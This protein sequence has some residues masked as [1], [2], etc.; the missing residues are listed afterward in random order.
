MSDHIQLVTA[1]RPCFLA[2]K[3]AN[4]TTQTSITSKYAADAQ[5]TS[6]TGSAIIPGAMNYLKIS[7][8]FV[9]GSAPTIR[10]IGWA[11]CVDSA[12]WI[13]H[14]ITEVVCSLDSSSSATINNTD[15]MLGCASFSKTFGD[16][17]IFNAT[18]LNTTGFIVVDTLGFDLVE[19]AFRTTTSAVLANAHIG[20]M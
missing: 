11:R 16:C 10:V 7:P 19:L 18:G 12:L 15:S 2:L 3:G 4:V 17:K 8:R 20:D 13:P 1:R 5:P 9:S 6:G 14:L